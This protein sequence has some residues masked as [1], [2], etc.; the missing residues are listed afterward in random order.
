MHPVERTLY[1]VDGLITYMGV[2]HRGLY[3]RMLQ[4]LLGETDAGTQG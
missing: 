1:P 3:A 2:N 4:Q